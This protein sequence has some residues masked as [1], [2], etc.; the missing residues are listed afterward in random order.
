MSPTITELE[1]VSFEYDLADVAYDGNAFNS[2]TTP[3]AP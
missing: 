3:E 2:S 1:T